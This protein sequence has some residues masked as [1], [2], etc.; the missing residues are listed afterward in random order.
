MARHF[1]LVVTLC[2]S[3]AGVAA[4]A[5]QEPVTP[6]DMTA[7]VLDES[8]AP[9]AGLEVV[10]V[11]RPWAEPPRTEPLRDDEKHVTDAEGR[12]VFGG[13]TADQYVVCAF[14]GDMSAIERVNPRSLQGTFELQLAAYPPLNIQF[15]D[16]HGQPVAGVLV[17][18][19]KCAPFALS[20][21]DGRVHFPSLKAS[22]LGFLKAGYGFFSYDFPEG[23]VE[24]FMTPGAVVEFTVLD[25]Q[26]KPVA[27]AKAGYGEYELT[28]DAEGKFRT[29]ELPGGTRV[30]ASASYAT[31][32][33][34]WGGNADVVVGSGRSSRLRLG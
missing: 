29:I 23:D 6:V 22:G 18:A 10:C 4:W 31:D 9:V 3:L 11:R 16:L 34:Q 25:D 24:I 30:S 26:G 7:R 32:S 2:L 19:D 14:R 21:A 15:R 8:G 33:A 17:L 28:T 1:S 13:L 12:C 5:Q 27:G 20:D